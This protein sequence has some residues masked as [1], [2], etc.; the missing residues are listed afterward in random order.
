MASGVRPRRRRRG[1]VRL[2]NAVGLPRW[3]SLIVVAMV[4]FLV[5]LVGH[6]AML[7]SETN[8]PHPPHVLLSSVGGEFAVNI[9]HAHLFDG[10]L[11]ECHNVFATAAVPRSATTLVERGVV[12]AVVAITAA[13][14]NL[15]V[16]A[17]R[18]PPKGPLTILT[19]QDL[20]TR[21]C[22]ARR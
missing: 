22:L 7:H 10:S 4:A 1:I 19:G 15:V 3:R 12:S 13:L 20:L 16:S 11:S 21:F 8:S 5:A 2:R 14:A 18:G 9:D 17:G 6:S